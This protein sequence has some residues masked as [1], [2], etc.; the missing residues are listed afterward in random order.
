MAQTLDVVGELFTTL[1]DNSVATHGELSTRVSLATPAGNYSTSPDTKS[2]ADKTLFTVELTEAS[3][4]VAV[5]ANTTAELR[6]V[7]P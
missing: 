3:A 6:S 1:Q 4:S 2:A 7:V 5:T